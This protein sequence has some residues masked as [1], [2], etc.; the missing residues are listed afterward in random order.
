MIFVLTIYLLCYYYLIIDIKHNLTLLSRA[1]TLL[2]PRF[3]RAALRSIPA[4]RKKLGKDG[5]ELAE[6][7]RNHSIYPVGKSIILVSFQSDSEVTG[8][9][10]KGKNDR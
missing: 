4:L 7:I 6:V 5:E 2:E 3:T 9:E 10:R 8:E 1:V